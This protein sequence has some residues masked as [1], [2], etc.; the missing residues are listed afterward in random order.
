MAERKNPGIPLGCVS[1]GGAYLPEREKVRE[2][3]M[4]EMGCAD[5]AKQLDIPEGIVILHCLKL[6]LPATGP[7]RRL[8]LP[9]EDE[10]WLRYHRREPKYANCPV[11]GKRS[12]SRLR[13]GQRNSAPAP[14]GTNFGM[15]G[16]GQ[17][18]KSM[19]GVL[20]VRIAVRFSTRLTRE[21]SRS[22]SVARTAILNSVMGEGSDC[23]W[24]D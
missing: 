12:S 8:P 14:A 6:G 2:L 11:C 9:E 15:T 20:C 13:A 16:G 17:K 19:A 24:K 23:F 21:R 4:R 18:R 3:R 5:I 7:C 1:D 10:E 22:A